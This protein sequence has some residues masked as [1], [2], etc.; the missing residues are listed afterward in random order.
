MRILLIN[1]HHFQYG[2]PDR[3]FFNVMKWLGDAGHECIP[4]SFDY[5]ETIETPYRE[6][7]PEPITGRGPCRVSNVRFTP[8]QRVKTVARMFHNGEVDR[9]FRQVIEET[10]PDLVYAIYLS[11]SFLP[12]L[13]RIASREYGLPV[14][15]RLSDFG[16]FCPSYLFLRDGQ[17]CTECLKSPMAAVKHRCVQHSRAASAL[18]VAQIAS[19]R[20][21]RW[22]ND[23][24]LFLAPS[25]FMASLLTSN[26]VAGHRVQHLPTAAA[27]TGRDDATWERDS[28]LYFGRVCPEKGAEIL[29]R[30]FAQLEKS[31]VKL[32]LAG[33]ADAGYEAKL[34][35]AAGE[36]GQR[37]EILPSQHGDALTQLIRR[38]KF[39]AHPALW[40]ENMPNS[41]L[42]SFAAS[43]PV[44]AS[45]IGSLPELVCHGANGWLVAPGSVL[46]WTKALDRALNE[47]D[48]A[49]MGEA[50]RTSYELNHTP[51]I[52]TSRLQNFFNELNEN[53]ALGR[54]KYGSV[55][56]SHLPVP[57]AVQD[58][59]HLGEP[60][61]SRG[62]V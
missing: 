60:H 31:G 38:A 37:V 34:M 51:Q 55:S 1:Y 41:V 35:A 3:Y 16:M 33:P 11:C 19:T 20:A 4:F 15:H 30:A 36:A 61:A 18:R 27:D 17:P 52:H 40:F 43:R 45:A 53:K 58:V 25:R 29:V 5:D 9:K 39:V 22:Y 13:F 21:N 49:L 23:V 8:A 10:K 54:A 6:Y 57:D 26:G 7:F 42:E 32:V 48:L 59:R 2:G 12:K 50:A 14:V 47:P 28:I 62:G 44:I 24:D 56:H 46:A